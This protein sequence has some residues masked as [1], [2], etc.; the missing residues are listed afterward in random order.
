MAD[1]S[2]NSTGGEVVPFAD[3]DVTSLTLYQAAEF[4]REL[5]H[6]IWEPGLEYDLAGWDAAA[7]EGKYRAKIAE[8]DA[9][10]MSL[11]D[12]PAGGNLP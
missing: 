9:Y 1:R 11:T 6:A 7:Q 8:V 12:D 4:R 3:V 2:V 10:L 5:I